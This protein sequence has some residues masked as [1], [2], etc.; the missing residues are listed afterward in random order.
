MKKYEEIYVGNMKKYMENKKDSPYI[1]ALGFENTPAFSMGQARG[2]VGSQIPGL[3]V[4][5]RKDM[6]HVKSGNLDLS[7]EES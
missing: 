7:V 2:W 5:Q 4:S 3:G 6:K 1:W